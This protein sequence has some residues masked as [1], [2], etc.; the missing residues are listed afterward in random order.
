VSTAIYL[1]NRT[2]TKTNEFK[3]PL[4]MLADHV[5]IPSILN[6]SPKIFGCVVY[7]HIQKKFHTKVESCAEKYIFLGFG[8]HKKWYKCYN[9]LTQNF[10][11]QWT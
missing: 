5:N 9:L 2:P 6:M 8:S 4:Q 1:I 7:V 11:Q 10:T 3:T